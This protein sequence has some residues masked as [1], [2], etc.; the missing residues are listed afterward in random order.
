MACQCYAVEKTVSYS[1]ATLKI[2]VLKISAGFLFTAQLICP[3]SDLGE[4]S[5]RCGD[6][7]MP[8]FIQTSLTPLKFV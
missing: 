4:L 1:F 2:H 7:L 6:N 3:S 5:S 8:V